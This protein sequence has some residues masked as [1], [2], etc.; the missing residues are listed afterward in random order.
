MFDMV[1]VTD[2]DAELQIKFTVKIVRVLK[3]FFLT[4]QLND[5][6]SQVCLDKKRVINS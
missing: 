3:R 1:D 4:L 2:D 6:F 5:V